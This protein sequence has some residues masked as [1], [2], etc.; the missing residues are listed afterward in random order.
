MAKYEITIP[1]EG[2][3]QI[4]SDVELTNDEA[5]Q[6][7]YDQMQS[8]QPKTVGGFVG[9]VGTDIGDIAKG[10]L[11]AAANPL[12]T[13]GGIA[14]IATTGAVNMLPKPLVDALFA[15]EKDPTSMQYK[16]NQYFKESPY[17]D[18]LYTA[19]REQYEKMGTEMGKELKELATVEG[20]T[21]RMY[22][23]PVTSLL[24]LTGVGRG[25]TAPIKGTKY[26]GMLN[27][28]FEVA[29]PTNIITKPIEKYVSKPLEE[30]AAK[31]KSQYAVSDAD[32]QMFSDY[33]YK[34][35]PSQVRTSGTVS[36]TA[37]KFVGDKMPLKVVQ[38]NQQVTNKLIRKHLDIPEGTPLDPDTILDIVR[39]RSSGKYQNVKNLKKHKIIEPDTVTY[40]KFGM[41]QTKKGKVTFTKSGAEL[42]QDLEKQRKITQQTFKNAKN[43]SPNAKKK[44]TYD[45]AYVEVEKQKAIENQIE[46]LARLKG[47]TGL[48]DDL[49]EA[50]KDYARAYSIQDSVVKGD[51]DAVQFSKRNKNAPLDRE[52]KVIADFA[53]QYQD[54]AKL[55]SSVKAQAGKGGWT[56]MLKNY[57]PAGLGFGIGAFDPT[58]AA[59]YFGGRGT[60]P[61]LLMSKTA[62]KR[63]L[64]PNTLGLAQ[65]LSR[66][67]AS[68]GLVGSSA[69][70]PSLLQSSDIEDLPY[71]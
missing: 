32:A 40:D 23:K 56:N 62:Q 18:F 21:N 55:S 31:T 59:I 12:D 14:D 67:G 24:E 5:I 37:E 58:L 7:V 71:L 65:G 41:P 33:G 43:P 1:D 52:G 27:K 35:T 28:G 38:E 54:I 4:E 15:Y 50:R 2:T 20:F 13:I 16:L 47:E 64:N 51:L 69:Y 53:D 22:E 29:D 3:F 63:M 68:Q 61:S 19:P 49:A 42:L 26:G 30:R 44:V 34:F 39:Q 60:I 25:V 48:L 66:A 9:N 45:D 70:I 10:T 46:E 36:S 17:L 8:Q 11:T 57:A 6:A